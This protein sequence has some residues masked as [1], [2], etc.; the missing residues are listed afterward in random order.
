MPESQRSSDIKEVYVQR[1]ILGAV[2]G[3]LLL[4]VGLILVI[5]KSIFI[6]LG[7]LLGAGGL[8]ALV[9]AAVQ[10]SKTRE[11]PDFSVDCPFCGKKNH[12]VEQPTS[13]F[14]CV[15]CNRM[16]PIQDGRMLRIFQVRCG[17]CNTLNYYSEKS[18]GLICEE[19]DRVIPIATDEEN[20]PTK[21]F[22]AFS[23]RDDTGTYDLTLQDAGNK[24]EEVIE[25]LQHMLALNR[26]QVKQII[27]QVPVVLL[28]G[29]PRR[30]AE[31]L[32]AQIDSHGAHANFTETRT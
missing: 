2:P 22:G 21:A 24:H 9:Y 20:A 10:Y 26:N 12:L 14:R 29:I 28:S 6:V 3:V 23:A 8:A 31:M 5:Y 27:E 4:V 25:C 32:K 7:L 18:T 30:K 17:Y 16:V 11:I 19:C 15:H 13:D 1:A